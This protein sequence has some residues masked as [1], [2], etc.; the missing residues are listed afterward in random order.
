MNLQTTADATRARVDRRIH[1]TMGGIVDDEYVRP[2]E[3]C[4]A[5]PGLAD[6]LAAALRTRRDAALAWDAWRRARREAAEAL[7]ARRPDLSI[8]GPE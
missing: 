4:P 7:R 8:Q 6:D 2:A 3:G 1:P 5:L